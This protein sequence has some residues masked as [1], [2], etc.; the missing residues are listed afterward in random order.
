MNSLISRVV[1][2]MLAFSSYVAAFDPYPP[3][4]TTYIVNINT[5]KFHDPDCYYASQIK[6]KNRW[7]YTGSREDLIEFKYVPC[8]VCNP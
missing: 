6:E 1:A 5:N 2:I 7:E 4:Q 8:G 3:P